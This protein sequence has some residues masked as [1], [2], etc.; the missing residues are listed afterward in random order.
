MCPLH[1]PASAAPSR[2]LRSLAPRARFARLAAAALAASAITSPA[3]AAADQQPPAAASAAKSAELPRRGTIG[4]G[5]GPAP[6]GQIAVASVRPGGPAERAGLKTG[7]LLLSIDGKPLATP[8]ALVDVI[9][10]KPAGTRLDF[11]IKRADAEQSLPVTLDAMPAEDIPR[12]KV[13]YSSVTVPAGYRLRTIITEPAPDAAA[14]APAAKHPAFLFIQGLQCQTIDRPHIL[15][16][17]DSRLVQAMAIAGYVTMRVD[18]PGLGD[19][20]GPPCQD[21][22]FETELAGYKAALDQLRSLPSVDTNRIYVFGHSMGGVMAPYL[23]NDENK[24][25]RGAIV[26]GTAVR[27]W[28]E[29]TLEN[30]RRQAALQG[31]SPADVTRAVQTDALLN[32]VV[33]LEKKTPGDAWA[34]YPQTKSDGPF[35]D[36]VRLFGRHATFFHQLQDLNLEEAWTSANANVLA[37]YG[38]YDWVTAKLDHDAIAELVNRTHPGKGESMVLQQA[39]HGFTVHAS[40]QDSMRKLG[41]GEW[42]GRLPQAVLAWIDR[43]E[44]RTGASAK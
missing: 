6:D 23:L 15:Q 35:S 40:L 21:I 5:L 7:D 14:K 3:L 22:N 26:Y 1:L 44:G 12:T 16:A 9:R 2:R 41:Q 34:R 10:G 11:R 30:T 17:P 18:K 25:V 38:E 36:P 29:Y 37:I 42:D 24:P 13:S 31:A 20:E 19:S 8:G 33:L 27:T 39:D 32:S 4:L 43:V 28:M